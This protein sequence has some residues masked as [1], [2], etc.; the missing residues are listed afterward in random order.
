MLK[1]QGL[2]LSIIVKCSL[3]IKKMVAIDIEELSIKTAY[4]GR[5]KKNE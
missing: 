3:K 1:S 2:V 4:K 5:G